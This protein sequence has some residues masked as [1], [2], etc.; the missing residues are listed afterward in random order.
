MID[1]QVLQLILISLV[2]TNVSA[3][4]SMVWEDSAEYPERTHVSKRATTIPYHTQPLSFTRIEL[5]SQR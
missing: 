3:R 1:E 4:G 5:G 2:A